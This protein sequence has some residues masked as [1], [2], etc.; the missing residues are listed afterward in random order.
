MAIS[1]FRRWLQGKRKDSRTPARRVCSPRLAVESLEERLMMSASPTQPYSANVP[2]VANALTHSA[3]YYSNFL[4]NIYQT[5]LGRLPDAAG[6]Q[7][8]TNAMSQGQVTDEQLLAGFVGS[9]EYIQD[10]GGAGAGWIQGMYKDLLGR[11]PLPAEVAQ[12]LG[13]LSGGV[14]PGQA[15]YGFAASAERE[16]LRVAV[17][18][19]A[20]VHRAGSV[21]EI[22]GWVGDFQQGYTNES[23]VAG[24]VGSAES[25]A[26]SGGN[27]QD[28]IITAYQEI[29][30][31]APSAD[32]MQNLEGVL[33]PGAAPQGTTYRVTAGDPGQATPAWDQGPASYI[34]PTTVYPTG[35]HVFDS[36]AEPRVLTG[37]WT[38]VGD[39]PPSSDGDG[40]VA[41]TPDVATLP[42]AERL[43]LRNQG[44]LTGLEKRVGDPNPPNT[45]PDSLS[46]TVYADDQFVSQA[47]QVFGWDWANNLPT[48]ERQRVAGLGVVGL[49]DEA[50]HL[51][52]YI[53]SCHPMP[54]DLCF[55]GVDALQQ[56][57]IAKEA[58]HDQ[59]GDFD[60]AY[61][62]ALEQYGLGD[63]V[64]HVPAVDRA[65]ILDLAAHVDQWIGQL[66]PAE[67]TQVLEVGLWGRRDED[68]GQAQLGA[69]TLAVQAGLQ[70][71]DDGLQTPAN[72]V[73]PNPVQGTGSTIQDPYTGKPLVQWQAGMYQ[74]GDNGNPGGPGQVWWGGNWM[75]AGEAVERIREAQAA[76]ARRA[77]EDQAFNQQSVQLSEQW[78]QQRVAVLQNEAQEEQ[79]NQAI[80]D[81]NEAMIEKLREER[82]VEEW[83]AIDA[84]L[85]NIHLN[86]PTADSVQWAQTLS[87]DLF[88]VTQERTQ[89]EGQEWQDLANKQEMLGNIF[90]KI[91]MVGQ[92]AGA[93]VENTLF[94]MSHGYFTG[95]IYGAAGNWDKGAGGMLANGSLSALSNVLGSWVNLGTNATVLG[96]IVGNASGNALIGAGAT[97][98]QGG[99]KDDMESAAL[100]GG[101]LGGFF[102]TLMHGAGY[103][104]YLSGPA[105]NTPVPS[106]T[107]L[108]ETVAANGLAGKKVIPLDQQSEVVQNLETTIYQGQTTDANGNLV[109]KS[110]VDTR[111]ALEQLTDTA[112]SRTAKQAPADVQQA[113]INTRDD[114]L[115]KPANDATVAAVKNNPEFQAWQ[116]QNGLTGLDPEMD[117]FSTPGKNGPSLGADRDARL[118]VRQ[119]DGSLREVPRQLWENQAYQDFF[120]QTSKLYQPS[121]IN[122]QAMPSLFERVAKLQ[123][124]KGMGLTDDQIM[125]RAWAE[126][127]NQLFTDKY[128]I[129]ASADNSDQF[130]AVG[131]VQLP[132]PG[133][134]YGNSGIAIDRYSGDANVLD[135]KTWGGELYD[136][137]DYARMWQEKINAYAG[138]PA[139]AMAQCQKGIAEMLA[140]RQGYLMNGIAPPELAPV[141]REAMSIVLNADVGVNANPAS[142]EQALQNLGFRNLQDA[143]IKIV[144]QNEIL[145]WSVRFAQ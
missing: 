104:G 34:A 27:A 26:K 48:A 106:E 120:Q 129:E 111:G 118:V 24:F 66:P 141:I 35:E 112:S 15:A 19:D 55:E 75:D 122:A 25:Y 127:H 13:A 90:Q 78:M 38:P 23:V 64:D 52:D 83:Q 2:A 139:E 14:T 124:L 99:S 110:Y 145:K 95:M 40:W 133:D 143:L 57:D 121:E 45:Q 69:I 18:Y 33:N 85:E 114:L 68:L 50:W 72:P 100:W 21:G 28:W 30:K 4:T 107:D 6:L 80:L 56:A 54:T 136:P 137:T 58:V 36:M 86:G 59:E 102:T 41:L 76:D 49:D 115:Y 117:S 7:T 63:W 91:A 65:R 11:S 93:A 20:Y 43:L 51:G 131:K 71:Q 37:N 81:K 103:A 94:P 1:S 79:V 138:N 77:A 9:P 109:D 116:Q 126:E 84:M 46:W 67:Q 61:V 130:T 98:L 113:I 125:S 32:E 135:V 108:V 29:L 140:V 73:D 70:I 60:R 47:I 96:N 74:P 89:L 101:G 3:E 119:P 42:A 22:N 62:T 5:Y 134:M 31:R 132:D 17:D 44:W 88:Q 144:S 82:P 12:W 123:Y 142:V 16:F 128:H 39:N 92:F 8:L 97:W 10:H 53:Y 87:H 105:E